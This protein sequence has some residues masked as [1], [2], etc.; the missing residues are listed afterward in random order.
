MSGA[1][2]SDHQVHSVGEESIMCDFQGNAKDRFPCGNKV[3]E[4]DLDR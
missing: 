2:T 1:K 4:K 3:L